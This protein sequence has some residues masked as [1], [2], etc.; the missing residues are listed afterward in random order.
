MS[1]PRDMLKPTAIRTLIVGLGRIGM[2]YDLD[3]DQR[4][5]CLSHARAFGEHP[6]FDLVGAVDPDADRRTRF[7]TAYNRPTFANVEAALSQGNAELVIVAVPTSYHSAT[8][9]QVLAGLNGRDAGQSRGRLMILCEK[10]LSLDVTEARSIVEMCSHHGAELFVNYM[11]RSDPGAIEVKRRME[12]RLI[13]APVKGVAWYSRGFLHNGSHFFNLLEHWLG[14][15]RDAQILDI[16]RSIGSDAE[17]DVMVRFDRGAVQFLA[18]PEESY[19]HYGVELAAANGRL[20]YDRGGA[21]IV[22]NGI[23][24][25]PTMPEQRLLAGDGERISSD[26]DRYQYHVATQLARAAAC[27]SYQLCTGA[28][29]LRT[30]ENMHAILD[31]R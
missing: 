1:T 30:L 15:V 29:A 6:S 20:R 26:M 3:L 17:P 13:A 14:A 10:P 21:E 2:E 9:R 16:G 22:W 19:S 27:E 23:V 11:R 4:R 31:S 28:E 24:Q 5:Y 12:E 25:H 18:L 7:E 8:I